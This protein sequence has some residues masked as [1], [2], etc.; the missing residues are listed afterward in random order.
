[1]RERC[2]G[3]LDDTTYQAAQAELDI[4]SKALE[5]NTSEGKSTF[6]LALKRLRGLIADIADLATKIATLI[7]TAKGLS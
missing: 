6:V 2:T 3:A 1:M 4:A 5:T 7:A